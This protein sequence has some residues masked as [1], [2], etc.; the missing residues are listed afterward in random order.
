MNKLHTLQTLQ[1]EKLV[2]VIRG[3]TSEEAEKITEGAYAGGIKIMEI[4]YTVPNASQL[5]E[6]LAG[7]KE[8]DWVIGAG[9]VLDE[10]TARMAILAGAR[11]IVAPNFNLNVAKLCNRYQIPYIPGCYT[12]NE[13]VEAM[14][15]GADVIKIFPGNT[16]SPS[17]IKAIKG[18]LPQANIMPSGG[19]SADNLN[20]WL[21]KGAVAVSVGGSLYKDDFEDIKASA[22]ELVQKL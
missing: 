21:E 19:V 13:V 16:I 20:E 15:A 12:V 7:D 22:E 6:K 3:E 14:E 11:F 10:V 8:R 9:T 1:D 2:A 5:I 4:T 18:P 17:G